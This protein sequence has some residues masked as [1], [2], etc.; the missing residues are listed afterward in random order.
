MEEKSV[1][2]RRKAGKKTGKTPQNP[3]QYGREL[4]TESLVDREEEF[5]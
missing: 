4:G 1:P 3:F 5:P 2:T